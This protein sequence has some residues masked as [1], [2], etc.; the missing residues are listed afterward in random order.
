MSTEQTV[1]SKKAPII[2][3]KATPDD[4]P[5]IF[6]AWLKS[7]EDSVVHAGISKTVYYANQHKLIEKLL[8]TSEVLIAVNA[9]DDNQIYGFLV[10]ERLQGVFVIHY[11][12]VKMMFR[13]LGVARTLL[14]ATDWNP[15]ELAAFTHWGKPASSISRKTNFIYHPYI[16]YDLKVKELPLE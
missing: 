6:S 3:R 10:C 15:E 9:S 14:E 13:K 5:F 12:Y 7:Y 4:V 8:R 1:K 11:I 2:V 16:L